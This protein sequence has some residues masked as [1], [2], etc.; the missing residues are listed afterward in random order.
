MQLLLLV[1]IYAYIYPF[2]ICIYI[3]QNGCKMQKMIPAEPYLDALQTFVWQTCL[4]VV[5]KMT[6]GGGGGGGV[7]DLQDCT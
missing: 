2:C 7:N 1:H 3:I 6:G 4:E 5:K